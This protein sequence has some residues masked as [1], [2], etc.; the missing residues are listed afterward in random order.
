MQEKKIM[1]KVVDQVRI[2]VEMAGFN[3]E[4]AQ[5]TNCWITSK[6]S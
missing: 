5:G 2:L 3:R 4:I 6:K 1:S